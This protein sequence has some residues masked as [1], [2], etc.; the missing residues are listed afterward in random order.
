MN[1]QTTAALILTL[2]LGGV[3]CQSSHV[4]KHWGESYRAAVARQTA[5]PEVSAVNA[6]EPAPQGLDGNTADDVMGKYHKKQQ[7]AQAS[8][9]PFSMIMSGGKSS[10]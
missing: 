9:N 6:D 8:Q 4:D 5:Q 3:G 7:P 10:K 1:S 2:L